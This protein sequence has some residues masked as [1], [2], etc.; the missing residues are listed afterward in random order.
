GDD[1]VHR[2]E[3]RLQFPVEACQP[4]ESRLDD[5]DLGERLFRA[6]AAPQADDRAVIEI[7][8]KPRLLR[9]AQHERTKDLEPQVRGAGVREPERRGNNADYLVT[10]AVEQDRLTDERPVRIE[11]RAPERF[12]KDRYAVGAFPL[13]FGKENAAQD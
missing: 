8:H 13:L 4:W 1:L 5:V 7:A 11:T 9:L 6:H 3:R 2:C 10:S 12:R